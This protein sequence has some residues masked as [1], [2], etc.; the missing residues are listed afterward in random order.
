MLNIKYISYKLFIPFLL[1]I[2]S[3]STEIV[4]DHDSYKYSVPVGSKLILNQKITIA[5]NQGRTF[6]QNGKELKNKDV[7]IYYPH[8]SITT[9]KIVNSERVIHAD[10]FEIYKII[11]DE[12]YAQRNVYYAS[13]FFMADN[14]GPSITGLVSYYYLRSK[15]KQDIRTLECLQWNSPGDNKYLSINEVKIALGNIFTLQLNE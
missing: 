4:I 13:I 10:S 8:C 12:E 9:H 2:S 14:Y 5:A 6:F 3:C 15:A 7:D 11:D 1:V